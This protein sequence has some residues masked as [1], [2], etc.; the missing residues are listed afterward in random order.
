MNPNIAIQPAIAVHLTNA[1]AI[2]EAL[3]AGQ[4]GHR[5]GESILRRISEHALAHYQLQLIC[6]KFS[7]V[8]TK[9]SFAH[10]SKTNESWL[11]VGDRRKEVAGNIQLLIER[12]GLGVGM[13][14]LHL[15][16]IHVRHILTEIAT[17]GGVQNLAVPTECL[18]GTDG[19][20]VLSVPIRQF[21]ADFARL[22]ELN[23]AKP[24]SL[25]TPGCIVT[26]E[27]D[28]QPCFY[29]S[30]PEINP[31]EVVIDLEGTR[32]GL[33]RDYALGFTFA[34]FGNPLST[35]HFLAWDR[36]HRPLNMN[37]TPVT[38]SDLVKFTR[39][40]NL[41]IRTFF[42]ET[43]IRDFPVIDG[44]TNGWAGNT[45]YHQHFQFFHPEHPSPITHAR[46]ING[47]P[48]INRDDVTVERLEWPCPVYRIH[49]PDALNT[50][51]VGNDLA[52][53]WRLLG[54]S[55]KVPYKTF[56]DGYTPTE[57]EKIHVH[58]QNLYVPGHD[59]GA[60]AYLVLRDRERVDF[61]PAPDDFINPG[62]G[63]KAQRKDN[64][65]ALE[66]TGTLI[67]DDRLCFDEMR[68]WQPEDISRQIHRMIAATA[69][70]ADKVA[71]F[72]IA[73]RELFPQ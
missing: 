17:D 37:R 49:A 22:A 16:Q 40:I 10:I 54:G 7:E 5:E 36:A 2:I 39:E 25:W 29:C 34:P 55:R 28:Q 63:F 32:H 72:E 24:Q 12:H 45:I 21:R 69:P 35:V 52:G 47:S 53:I 14:V 15:Q 46:P 26:H 62:H 42:A 13:L 3:L 38:V 67:V 30:C 51:L 50:G 6:G 1:A 23:V 57:G 58:T 20:H 31:A 48:I 41:S 11:L 44:I 43:G 73:I 33:S 60:T 27:R 9:P 59:L 65:G 8:I 71:E 18:H 70:D 19:E 64:L 66:T 4:A 68:R 61:R 56:R